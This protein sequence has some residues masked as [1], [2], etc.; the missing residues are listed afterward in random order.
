MKKEDLQWLAKFTEATVDACRVAPGGTAAKGV[1]NQLPF[2][3]VRP[4]GRDCYPA[5]WVQDFTMIFSS[6]FLQDAEGLDHLKL[7]LHCQNSDTIRMLKSGAIIPPYAIPDHIRLDGRPVFFPGTYSAE[8]DQGGEPWGICPPYNNAFDV[9]WL[10]HMLAERTGDP[11]FLLFEM[12][13]DT[14]Y[15]RLQK[16]YAVPLCDSETGIVFTTPE[17]RAVGFIFCDSVY[18][19]GSLLMAS[20]LRIR[21]SDH[22]AD[23]ATAIGREE[24]AEF[25]ALQAKLG[26]K[27]IEMVFAET[28]TRKGWLRASTGISSQT[29][30]WGTIYAIW[31]KALSHEGQQAARETIASALERGTIEFNGALRHIPLGHDASTT[32]AW[33]RTVTPHNRYQNGAYWHM[34]TGWLIA[35]LRETHPAIAQAITERYLAHMQANVFTLGSTFGAPWECIGLERDAWQNPIFGPSATVPYGVLADLKFNR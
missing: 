16:A 27:H 23:L 11:D 35:I 3:A 33:E 5:I 25:Y 15:E 34:P 17:A 26:R 20:L 7:F 24:D 14:I 30:V 21:A 29:D 2:T 12:G 4:G 28:G 31:L 18:M 22:L 6:G 13:G 32:S 19:T 1:V 8:E 9:V 10:A